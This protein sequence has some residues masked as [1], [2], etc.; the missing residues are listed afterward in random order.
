MKAH[1]I[2]F[3]A[4]LRSAQT[5]GDQPTLSPTSPNTL[6]P[7]PTSPHQAFVLWSSPC[8]LIFLFAAPK[9]ID[10]QKARRWPFSIASCATRIEWVNLSCLQPFRALR[11]SLNNS[12]TRSLARSL[13]RSPTSTCFS[14]VFESDSFM[15][16]FLFAFEAAFEI[17]MFVFRPYLSVVVVVVEEEPRFREV[18]RSSRWILDTSSRPWEMMLSWIFERVLAFSRAA[19][20]NVKFRLKGLVTTSKS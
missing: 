10:R 7:S 17:V 2:P 19:L 16:K 6:S 3:N 14:K 9:R 11:R 8:S 4:Y 20:A 13:A 5:G 18:N 15:W 1:L 12:L